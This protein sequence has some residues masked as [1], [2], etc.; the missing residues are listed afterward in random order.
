METRP[1]TSRF[2]QEITVV[3][4]VRIRVGRQGLTTT[5]GW[6]G[7]RLSHSTGDRRGGSLQHLGDTRLSGPLPTD[8]FLIPG[9]PGLAGWR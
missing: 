2:R 6:R 5:I 9:S 3:L 7:D 8:P 1:M 4:D